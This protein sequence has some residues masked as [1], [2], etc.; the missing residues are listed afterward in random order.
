MPNESVIDRRRFLMDGIRVTSVVAPGTTA[1]VLAG[2][3]GRAAEDRWQIDPDKCIACTNCATNCVLDVSAVKCVHCFD[4]CGYCDICTGYFEMGYTAL[5]TAAEN[6]ALPDRRDRPQVRRGE[7]RAAVLRVHDRRAA[8]HRVRQVRQGL[9]PD[10]RLALPASRTRPLRELQRVRDRDRLSESGLHTCAVGNA[11]SVEEASADIVETES[12]RRLGR[13][14]GGDSQAGGPAMKRA[15][16]RVLL[17][18][19]LAGAM[20][21]ILANGCWRNSV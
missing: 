13:R 14:S 15:A 7:A 5:D 12:G 16:K 21:V 11:L 10:E 18:L 8:V 1:G 9:C 17:R 2:R 19:L 4:M 3:Q 20:A 6:Q